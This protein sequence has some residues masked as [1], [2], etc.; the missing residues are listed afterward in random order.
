M[1]WVIGH[2]IATRMF[3]FEL[4]GLE[5]FWPKETAELYERGSKPLQD[6]ASAMPLKELIATF[7]RT[8][9]QLVNRLKNLDGPELN[10]PLEGQT[11]LLGKTKG[12]ALAFLQWH[13][14][15]H[16]GQVGLLRRVAGKTGAIP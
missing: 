14:A 1:N 5:P 15:Y 2:V 3:I 6:P 11:G 8:Q 7:G 10:A 12:E 9:Q 13:E 4:I 16:M